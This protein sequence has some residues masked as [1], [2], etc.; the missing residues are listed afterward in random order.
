MMY[1]IEELESTFAELEANKGHLIG[2]DIMASLTEDNHVLEV[3]R[4]L[5]DTMRENA[6]LRATLEWY[7]KEENYLIGLVRLGRSE[8]ADD[9]GERA[10]K[11]LGL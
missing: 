3:M 10:R 6:R 2:V 9:N 5:L 8:L 11:E 1:T 7:A 4:Q